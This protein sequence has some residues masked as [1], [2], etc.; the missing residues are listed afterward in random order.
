[1]DLLPVIIVFLHIKASSALAYTGILKRLWPLDSQTCSS[2]VLT[3]TYVYGE[4]TNTFEHQPQDFPFNAMEFDGSSSFD[5]SV[6]VS[7]TN[8]K[9]YS[10]QGWFFFKS[11]TP[12]SLFH[13][14]DSKGI[15]ETIVWTN[16]MKLKLY[17]K[18]KSDVKS[19][20]GIQQIS[21]YRWYYIVLGVG[22]EGYVSVRIDGVKDVY[23]MLTNRKSKEMPGTLRIGGDFREA[24][25][26]VKGRITCVGFH[27]NTRDASKNVV[28]DV[29]TE[30]AWLRKFTF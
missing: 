4:C 27:L 8:I 14:R 28:E 2:E 21:K 24:H 12:S 5:V 10:F 11:D 22:E 9:H 29:C 17:R 18:V 1:M 7:T 19:F 20:T 16:N 25:A 26:N 23:G 13:Y 3:T 6:D 30:T 15:S